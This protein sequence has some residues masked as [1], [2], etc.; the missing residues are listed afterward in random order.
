MVNAIVFINESNYFMTEFKGFN[1]YKRFAYGLLVPFLLP[2]EKDGVKGYVM[3]LPFI[4]SNERKNMVSYHLLNYI[5]I[6]PAFNRILNFFDRLEEGKCFYI[7]FEESSQDFYETCKETLKFYN[8]KFDHEF[9]KVQMNNYIVN[10]KI[11][12]RIL[13]ENQKYY[14]LEYHS[15][16]KKIYLGEKDKK[17]RICRFCGRTMADKISFIK[18]AHAIPAFMGNSKIFQ[19]EECDE[20]NAYFGETI[21]KDIDNYSK[22]FRVINGIKGRSGV[23]EVETSDKMVFYSDVEDVFVGPV[24]LSKNPNE[25]I[26]EGIDIKSDS[27]FIPTNVY[28]MFCKMFLSVIN[29]ENLCFFKETIDWVRYNISF[30]EKLPIA[31]ICYLKNSK[32]IENPEIVT[33][34]E[35]VTES[36]APYAFMEFRFGNMVYVIQIPSQGNKDRLFYTIGSFDEFLKTIEQFKHV[37]FQYTDF[38]SNNF[39]TFKMKVYSINFNA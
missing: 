18:D 10:N 33:Y 28:R 37:Q 19:N 2:V 21:E 16:F 23:P 26:E 22:L 34:I 29:S 11:L 12:E 17:K 5:K 8:V 6:K 4:M 32:I 25:K 13:T 38:S 30:L 1:D 39:T 35:K 3:E 20:C 9:V 36:I 24:V 27:K 31:A 7:F 14:D 15:Y